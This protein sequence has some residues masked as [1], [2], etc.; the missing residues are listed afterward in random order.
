MSVESFRW[1]S[2]EPYAQGFELQVGRAAIALDPGHRAN[3]PI[4]DLARAG[5]DPDGLVRLEADVV[6]LRAPKPQG[7]LVVVANRGMVTAL[8]YGDK[9]LDVTEATGRI[10]PGDGFTLRRGLSVLWVGWQWDV[11][12][13]P[14]VV[15]IDAP[16]ALASDGQPIVGQARLG[17]Q[18]R[19]HI[20]RRRLADE[21][22]PQMGRFQSLPVVHPDD[23]TAV[24]T[25]RRWFNGPRTTIERGRWRFCDAEHIE[26]DGGFKER[27]Y[28]ELTYQ[29]RRC[30]VA[31]VGLAAMRDVVASLRPEHSHVLALGIS[32]SGRW[33]RQF[34]Y[35]TAN[36]DESGQR[37]FDGIHCHLA[38]GRR[39]EFNHRYAQ[40][41]VMNHLGFSHLPPFAPADGLFD[42]AE[43]L[44]TT[45]DVLFT[46]TATEYWRGDAS[47]VHPVPEGHHWRCYLYAGAHHVGQMAGYVE[48][49]PVQ[50]QGN[51]VNIA[52][53]MRAH[54]VALEEWVRDGIAPPSSAVP[55]EEDASA[56]TREAALAALAEMPRFHEV[57]LPDAAAL[58][59]MPPIDLGE[60]ADQGVGRFPPEVTGPARRCVVCAIDP[61]GNEI[62]GVALPA[63]SVPLA[64]SVG[65]NPELPRPGVPVE[66]WNLVGGRIDFSPEEVRARY[67]DRERHLGLVTTA[68]QTLVTQRHL[69]EEDLG[70][71][72][73]E[74]RE[75]WDRVVAGP[76]R[77]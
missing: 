67:G 2:S 20:E 21:A 48:S 51:L 63:V 4:V 62:A 14:G 25:T 39:G 22:L 69:L 19:E 73:R 23:P 5:R 74:A 7:L 68:A 41:S 61:D 64:A 65:W 11:E 43:A 50:L 59:G 49:L 55:R 34:I 27:D 31:G 56:T 46:N 71:V 35:D 53:L 9:A 28:Y 15:G 33:L 26:L 30:P 36:A 52:P 54:L 17:F 40:P 12:R 66:I 60:Q 38:G 57:T 44:G 47:L 29:T 32:Q 42:R 16:E 37:V 76:E 24:L 70:M 77:A 10:D 72:L 6:Y 45:P 13:R 8:P 18:P 3:L 75:D 58:L 1:S